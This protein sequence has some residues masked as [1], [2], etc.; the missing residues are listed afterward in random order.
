MF[1]V[2]AAVS[3][4]PSVSYV[5]RCTL[6]ALFSSLIWACLMCLCCC[7]EGRGGSDQD[8]GGQGLEGPHGDG[9]PLRDAAAAEPDLLLPSPSAQEVSQVSMPAST[10]ASCVPG[11]SSTT[12]AFFS[13]RP[14]CPWFVPRKHFC[15]DLDAKKMAYPQKLYREH[16][17]TI[18]AVAD[19]KAGVCPVPVRVST[20]VMRHMCTCAMFAHP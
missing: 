10:T 14:T 20:H 12:V 19:G 4:S 3:G 16:L 8:Q 18:S 2:H 9:L 11:R 5:Y 17:S 15:A 6:A 7:A 13:P 1:G